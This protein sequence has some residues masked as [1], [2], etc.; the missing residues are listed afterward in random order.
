MYLTHRF[1]SHKNVFLPLFQQTHIFK[2]LERNHSTLT[3]SSRQPPQMI[4]PNDDFGPL[5]LLS[6]LDEQVDETFLSDTVSTRLGLQYLSPAPANDPALEVK[7][8]LSGWGTRPFLSLPLSL[9]SDATHPAYNVHFLCLPNESYTCLSIEV[10]IL[11]VSTRT[12]FFAPADTLGL[13]SSLRWYR[14]AGNICGDDFGK[15]YTCPSIVDPI[16]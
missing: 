9:E 8:V 10:C 6:V 5:N 11:Q 1:K 14:G 3:A 2:T 13:S 16:I 15:I 7:G 12:P 4:V